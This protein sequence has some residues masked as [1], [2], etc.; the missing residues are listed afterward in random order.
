[1]RDTAL[2]L[3][4][5]ELGVSRLALY[6]AKLIGLRALTTTAG[7]TFLLEREHGS[8]HDTFRLEILDL[9]GGRLAENLCYNLH[10]RRELAED[11]HCLHGGRE[12]KTSILE[13]GEV[14]QHLCYH[15]S[16][17]GAGRDGCRKELAKLSVGGTDTGGTK[18]LLEVVPHILNSSKVSDSNLD[19]GSEV[20]GN[21]TKCS[22][23]VIVPVVSVIVTVGRLGSRINV[24]LALCPKVGLHTGVPLLPV[25]ASE[26]R[27]HLVESTGHGEFCWVN[28]VSK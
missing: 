20:Q 14:A 10:S 2:L 9:V 5:G 16:W 7:S 12:V 26:H 1:V 13:V 19:G 6:S 24:P 18:A 4:L 28:G 3:L 25:G 8:L 11:N 17:M 23:S 15:G 21:I 27:D 22:L